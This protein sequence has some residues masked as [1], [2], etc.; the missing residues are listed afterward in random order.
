M[1]LEDVYTLEH[2]IQGDVVAFES[3][4]CFVKRLQ[5]IIHVRDKGLMF[6]V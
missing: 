2:F 1:F 6:L 4:C 5:E 3:N